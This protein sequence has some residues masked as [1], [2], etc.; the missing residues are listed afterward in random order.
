MNIVSKKL[1][2]TVVSIALAFTG[3]TQ[4]F[5]ADP[6]V[7]MDMEI[8]AYYGDKLFNRVVVVDVN[9]MLLDEEIYTTGEDPYPVDQAGNLGKVYAVTRGSDS[10]H[11]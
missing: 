1:C 9:R 5:A 11:I 2:L 8:K 7:S 10:M 4:V 3:G 6:D